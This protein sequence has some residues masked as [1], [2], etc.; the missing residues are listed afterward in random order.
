MF[1]PLLLAVLAFPSGAGGYAAGEL[2]GSVRAAEEL[3]AANLAVAPGATLSSGIEPAGRRVIYRG[4]DGLFRLVAKVGDTPVR[5]IVD[6]GATTVVLAPRDAR[7]LGITGNMG[8]GAVLQTAGGASR[9]RWTH[10]KRIDV[11]GQRLNAV[12]AAIVEGGLRHS[13][14]GQNVLSQLGTIT[15]EGDRLTI[16]SPSDSPPN[17]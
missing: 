9:M 4:G 7:R 12:D 16:N 6:T 11:A 2:V 10:I 17:G 5:F 1:R 8:S 13:L 3:A 14:L 15:I